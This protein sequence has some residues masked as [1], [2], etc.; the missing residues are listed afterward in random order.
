M[1]DERGTRTAL[2]RLPDVDHDQVAL[3]LRGGDPFNEETMVDDGHGTEVEDR[4]PELATA[5]R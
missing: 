3:V 1:V 2:G 5:Q 4:E